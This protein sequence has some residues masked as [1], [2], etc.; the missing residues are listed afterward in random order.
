MES[1]DFSISSSS[2]KMTVESSRKTT[3][4]M[5]SASPAGG[6]TMTTSTTEYSVCQTAAGH[7]PAAGQ[8]LDQPSPTAALPSVEM[9]F[10]VDPDQQQPAT[11]PALTVSYC[12]R[13]V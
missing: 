3:T 8:V 9:V 10:S 1:R 13:L 5:S 12:Y 11:P 6:R 4:V 7:G 2:R